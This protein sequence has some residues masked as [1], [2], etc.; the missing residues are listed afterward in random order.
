MEDTP[1]IKI[2]DILGEFGFTIRWSILPHWVDLAVFDKVG[3]ELGDAPKTLYERKGARTS[4][5]HA[6]NIDE[7]EPYMEGYVKWDGCTGLDIVSHHWCGLD[8]YKRHCD[9]LQYIY[10]RSQQLMDKADRDLFGGPWA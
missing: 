5:D 10:T 6:Y 9:L 7:A 2:E 4:E 3:M 1:V 8:G